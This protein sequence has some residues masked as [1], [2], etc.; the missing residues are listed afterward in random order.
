MAFINNARHFIFV[1]VFLFAIFP[2]TSKAISLSGWLHPP[3]TNGSLKEEIQ[4]YSLPYGGIGFASH[5]LTY[6]TI[7][8]LAF[9][10]RPWAPWI[11][12]THSGL[13]I[14]LT[15]ISLIATIIV[16]VLTIIRC[17]SR[18]QFIAIAA[19]KLDLSLTLGFLSLHAALLLRSEK[20][21]GGDMYNYY[22]DAMEF[23]SDDRFKVLFWLLLYI[24]GV[25]AGMSGLLSLVAETIGSNHN[26][27][28]VT[29]VFGSVTLT[30]AAIVGLIVCFAQFDEDD[31][32]ALSLIFSGLSAVGVALMGLG[33][34]G[35]FYSDWILGAIA[36]NMSGAPS[37]DNAAL[38][39]SYFIAKRLPFFSS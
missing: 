5:I 9:Q 25:A 1:V 3:Y 20:H 38:Y 13:D 22:E 35:A 32:K 10:R 37:S 33:V 31:S 12:N 6:Y 19:W 30:C 29:A 39:W 11:R 23:V 24:P 21:Q 2:N 18:W 36:N 34:L 8:M 28:V 15:V 7:T 14:L 26:V 4:C 17:R 27:L 16:S